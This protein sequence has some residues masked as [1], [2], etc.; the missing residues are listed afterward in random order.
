MRFVIA[1]VGVLV[2]LG[3]LGAIK[4][5]QFAALAGFGQEQAEQGPPPEAVAVEVASEHQWETTLHAVGSLMSQRGVSISTEVPGVV[6]RI[7]FESGRVVRKGD[8]LVELDTR[9][10]KAELASAFARERLA[11]REAARTAALVPA[12]AAPRAELDSAEAELDTARAQVADV[13]A[14][15]ALK[16]IRAPFSGRLGIRE[17]DL[18]QYLAPGTTITVLETSDTIFVD[19]TLPQKHLADV[20]VG[21]P[22]RIEVGGEPVNAT[23]FAVEPAVDVSTRVVRL[24]ALVK[25]DDR[26]LRSGMFVDVEV[27]LPRTEP[28]VAVPATAIVH[29]P[30]GDS[31]FVLEDKPADEPGMRETPDGRP[32][33][34]ARQRFV[35]TG[36][37]RGDFV[38]ILEGITAGDPVVSA[39]AF[40]LRNGAPVVVTD[41]AMPEPSLDS[42]PENR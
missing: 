32:V 22:V 42:Q 1:I 29:A 10:E 11:E 40:K 26:L 20:R 27:V 7:A 24:R 14:R 19:F 8:L 2:L 12:G 18:G 35:R 16:T 30:Y 25:R 5:A 21:M 38:A 37:R 31:L 6:A 15:I 34:V 3:G 13:R 28:F 9:V 39:G 23:I 4:G 36:P 17:V 41:T 33:L